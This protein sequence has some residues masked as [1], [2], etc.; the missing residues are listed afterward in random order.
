MRRGSV[1]FVAEMRYCLIMR[2]LRKMVQTHG[3]NF[4][5]SVV[6]QVHFGVVD[7]TEQ[8]PR[9]LCPATGTVP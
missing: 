2:R 5:V 7:L 3:R 6:K 4:V 1:E 8:G 9:I